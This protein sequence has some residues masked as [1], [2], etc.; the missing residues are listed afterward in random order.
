MTTLVLATLMVLLCGP[1]AL[2]YTKGAPHRWHQLL[3]REPAKP[4]MIESAPVPKSGTYA[5][6]EAVHDSVVVAEAD[7]LQPR[8][9]G[10]R[11]PFCVKLGQR[12]TVERGWTTR[13]LLATY[14]YWDELGCHE[15]VDN[16]T[17]TT[18]YTCSRGHHWTQKE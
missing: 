12:S 8:L 13:T 6:L 2:H 4:C 7:T 17:T 3:T 9:V 15:Y 18:N 16:N 10:G 14:E 11:C 5:D 1:D